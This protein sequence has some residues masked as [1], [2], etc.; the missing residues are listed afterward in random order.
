VSVFVDA[1][2]LGL[3]VAMT[4]MYAISGMVLTKCVEQE[5]SGSA[6][7]RGHFPPHRLAFLEVNVNI[8]KTHL[9]DR[10]A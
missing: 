10:A 1:S 4:G 2:S 5:D 9:M 3:L 8:S 7:I 6:W